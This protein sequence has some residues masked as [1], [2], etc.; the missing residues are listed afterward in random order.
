MLAYQVKTRFTVLTAIAILVTTT[1]LSAQE[2]AAE[3]RVEQEVQTLIRD[4]HNPDESVRL[5][6][7]KRLGKIGS[8][9]SAALPALQD[10]LKDADEDVRRIAA[11][12]MQRIGHGMAGTTWTGT[13]SLAGFGKLAFEFQ[14]GGKV[15]MHDA[16]SKVN[17][18]WKQDGDRVTL[19]FSNCVYEGTMKDGGL[20]GKA[21]FTDKDTAWTFSVTRQGAGPAPAVIPGQPPAPAATPGQP[22]TPRPVVNPNV[23]TQARMVRTRGTLAHGRVD[24]IR[25]VGLLNPANPKGELVAGVADLIKLIAGQP[26]PMRVTLDL[27]PQGTM[28]RDPLAVSPLVTAG[29]GLASGMSLVVVELG[30]GDAMKRWQYLRTRFGSGNL[31][32]TV[33]IPAAD[34][35]AGQ[36]LYA[37]AHLDAYT[38]NSIFYEAP[39]FGDLVM[40]HELDG[41]TSSLSA[42]AFNRKEIKVDA[43]FGWANP[44][45]LVLSEVSQRRLKD[46]LQLTI[47]ARL[48]MSFET[49]VTLRYAAETKETTRIANV[50]LATVRPDGQSLFR[51][52]DFVIAL[53]ATTEGQVKISAVATPGPFVSAVP[54]PPQSV[55]LS[56][57]HSKG[58]TL[59]DTLTVQVKSED[60]DKEIAGKLDKAN[61]KSGDVQVSLYWQSK[62][63]LD[64]H[65]MAPSGEA[66]YYGRRKSKCGG[67][68]DVDMNV[69]YG[70]AVAGAVENVYWPQGKAPAGTYKVYVH[71]YSHH[72]K[73][74][75]CLD[76]APFTV[77][78]VIQGRAQ[79]FR[80]QVSNREAAQRKVLVHEFQLR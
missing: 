54:S 48:P 24:R 56:T 6:A 16:R 71:H 79:L 73:Q 4:L 42:S 7:A 72:G 22:P 2:P 77:R 55:G 9:A 12:A 14:G 18:T 63:D 41:G 15:V 66:I 31:Y 60:L 64:L 43:T 29:G 19:T 65:V 62:D 38:A 50:A 53:P 3:Q 40:H 23:P 30:P 28:P 35:N 49:P 51:A 46:R 21:R 61:A 39:D 78:V 27:N 8:A 68:L 20:S 25:S 11:D 69:N 70:R 33:S 67:E 58:P 13:E 26:D 32:A 44:L 57:F 10:A 59:G 52:A 5:R 34:I 36:E 80:G 1:A 76:P 74:P 17:G 45:A 47:R 75:G 37:K